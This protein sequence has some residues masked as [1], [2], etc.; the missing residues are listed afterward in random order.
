M[1]ES[2]NTRIYH[3]TPCLISDRPQLRNSSPD[4]HSAS[5]IAVSNVYTSVV[6][7]VAQLLGVDDIEH[8]YSSE[9][10]T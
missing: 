9:L 8:R 1:A 4:A 5:H 2:E 10:I 7:L 6:E 3:P